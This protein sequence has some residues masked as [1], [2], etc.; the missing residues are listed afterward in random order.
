[1]WLI[2]QLYIKLGL[3]TLIEH[4]GATTFFY[5]A[6]QFSFMDLWIYG[7]ILLV[8]SG[9]WAREPEKDCVKF[10]KLNWMP[11]KIYLSQKEIFEPKK[12]FA[13]KRLWTYCVKLRLFFRCVTLYF[14]CCGILL[15]RKRHNGVEYITEAW[16]FFLIYD[17]AYFIQNWIS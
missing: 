8:N 2:D 17:L 9:V 14:K 7:F 10:F 15:K 16:H 5:F 1:M 11:Q 3:D 12:F 4:N 6:F 13:S